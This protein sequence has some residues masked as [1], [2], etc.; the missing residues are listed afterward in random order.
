MRMCLKRS[1]G[2][3]VLPIDF[4]ASVL[5]F[6]FCHNLQ[7]LTRFGMFAFIGGRTKR[8]LIALIEHFEPGYDK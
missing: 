4:S 5:I 7:N 3:P 6:Y 2:I 1:S 8:L